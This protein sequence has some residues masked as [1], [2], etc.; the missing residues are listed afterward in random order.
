MLLVIQQVNEEFEVNEAHLVVCK[1]IICQLVKDFQY[2]KVKHVAR[3]SNQVADALAVRGPKFIQVGKEDCP[4]IWFSRQDALMDAVIPTCETEEIFVLEDYAEWYSPII[5]F[6]SHDCLL[7]NRHKAR[8]VHHATTRHV[9]EDG[10]LYRRELDGILLRCLTR[11]ERKRAMQEA[12]KGSC[13][14]HQRGH[15]LHQLLLRISH[16][17]PTM[18]NDC[19]NYSRSYPSCHLHAPLKHLP[20]EPL[21]PLHTGP[22]KRGGYISFAL[23]T[24]FLTAGISSFLLF[25][26][27]FPSG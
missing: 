25:S 22:S 18:F 12:H 9:L 11:D 1:A 8:E 2:I 3:S 19:V 16:Y 27:I 24:Y 7:S 10:V 21:H 23:F 5:K 26:S 4:L 14:E 15:R 20:L 13:G 6:L 17:W